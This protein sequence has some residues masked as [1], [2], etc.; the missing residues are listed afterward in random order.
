MGYHEAMPE[1]WAKPIAFQL[2]TFC[3]KTGF[4]ENWF[5]G[6]SDNKTYLM[7]RKEL[8]QD[9]LTLCHIKE[10]EC[11]SKHNV[12]NSSSSFEL[13]NVYDIGEI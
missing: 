7:E 1:K 9:E 4:W 2:F 3:E 8:K 13:S 11:Y 6:V 10:F 12:R 5:L